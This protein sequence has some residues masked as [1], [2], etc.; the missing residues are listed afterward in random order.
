MIICPLLGWPERKARA[1]CRIK[2]TVSSLPPLS[3]FFAKIYN[4]SAS[5]PK[6]PTG[7]E[8]RLVWGQVVVFILRAAGLVISESVS[9]RSVEICL[10]ELSTS[11]IFLDAFALA[12][13]ETPKA[14]FERIVSPQNECLRLLWPCLFNSE[15]ARIITYNHAH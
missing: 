12:I 1:G 7:G 4:F 13:F 3:A 2:Q 10:E 9:G 15:P 6:K 14:G 5:L 11:F 8:Q